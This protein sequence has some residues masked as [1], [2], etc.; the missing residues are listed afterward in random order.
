MLNVI[1]TTSKLD[2]LHSMLEDA[3]TRAFLFRH[4]GS[5]RRSILVKVLAALQ[6]GTWCSR[7]EYVQ[8]RKGTTVKERWR[9]T[10]K[11]TNNGTLKQEQVLRKAG[12]W[13]FKV[14]AN[15]NGSKFLHGKNN[16][17]EE[18]K[19]LLHAYLKII[20]LDHQNNF[21]GTSKIIL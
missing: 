10:K 14:T 8:R 6:N 20:L 2:R 11:N 9:E 17:A 15:R 1:K 13:L 3:F 19:I 5:A 4:I 18:S 21:I 12:Q 7:T 16:F